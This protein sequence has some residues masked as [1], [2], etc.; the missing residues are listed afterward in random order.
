M[1]YKK[2]VQDNNEYTMYQTLVTKSD[3]GSIY[4]EIVYQ[5]KRT[6]RMF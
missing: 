2:L 1:I 6:Q 3:L 4:I 5:E